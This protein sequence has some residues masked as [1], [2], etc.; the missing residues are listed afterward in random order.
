MDPDVTLRRRDTL[1]IH[2]TPDDA[3]ELSGLIQ[4]VTTGEKRRFRGLPALDAAI[5]EM[6]RREPE[7]APPGL[8]KATPL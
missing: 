6:V 8:P 2:V 5:R 7:P 3:G 4:H 1:I